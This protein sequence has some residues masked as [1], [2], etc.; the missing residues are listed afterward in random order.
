MLARLRKWLRRVG[1]ALGIVIATVL[2]VRAFDAWRS[3]PLKLWHTQV[4]QELDEDDIDAANWDT[5][6]A[7]ENAAFAEMQRD[8]IDALP[9]EDRIA[10]GRY[11]V[12]SPLNPQRFAQNW[13]RSYVQKPAGTPRGAV[14]LVHGLTD[15]PYSMRHI[16]QRYVEHGYVAVAIRVPGHGTVP[17]GLT[18]TRWEA[19]AAATR[20]AVRTARALAGEGVPLHMVGYSNGGALTLKYALDSLA[21]PRLA[22]PD[23]LVLISPMVG[24][25]SFAR[26]AGVLGWPAAFPSFAKAAWLDV[27]PEYNPFKYNSFPVNAARQ[28]SQVVRAVEDAFISAAKSGAL[29]KLP[30]VLTFQSVLDATVSTGAVIQSL[31]GNLPANGSE[32]VI[33]DR[34]HRAGVGPM[35]RPAQADVLPALL[36]P[37]PRRFAFTVV[38]NATGDAGTD[39]ARTVAAGATGTQTRSLGLL[40]PQDLYSLSHV[41]LPFPPQDGLYGSE[42]VADEKF[43][44]RLGM[45][46]VRGERGALIVGA[47]TL[48]RASSNPF[49]GYMLERIEADIAQGP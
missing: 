44:V 33:F 38:G 16:A 18:T 8:V 27:L 36:P 29:A 24:I 12:D 43:G 19:W 4:P 30:P 10:I 45:V 3:P 40:Y 14:V 15:S 23:R 7:A 47:E 2:F 5:W 28:S 11:F 42:P 20:L 41:A 25:T 26:F 34:N 32:L 46:A 21:D 37:A 49:F 1:I 35:I 31:Y 13:N 48:M 22:R 17:A 6:V 9:A 39:E